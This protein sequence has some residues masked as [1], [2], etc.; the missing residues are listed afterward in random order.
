MQSGFAWHGIV[1]TD[2]RVTCRHTMP[3]Q[4][5]VR[6]ATRRHGLYSVT[7]P[8][9]KAYHWT[10]AKYLSN[11]R[12][13][14]APRHD[15]P[16]GS[17]TGSTSAMVALKGCIGSDFSLTLGLMP[18]MVIQI[19]LRNIFHEGCAAILVI[20]A[21]KLELLAGHQ[22]EHSLRTNSNII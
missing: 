17:P 11:F 21:Q 1:N 14:L 6:R 2:K 19:S 13:L 5:R 9:I 8:V 7:V 16:R 18:R 15:L 10:V 22:S 3:R 20:P 4:L 12:Q